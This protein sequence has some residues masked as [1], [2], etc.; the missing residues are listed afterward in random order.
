MSTAFWSLCG[1]MHKTIFW[2][3][4]TLTSWGARTVKI[5]YNVSHSE[6]ELQLSV[7]SV[8]SE[9]FSI[10][11]ITTESSSENF[12]RKIYVLRRCYRCWS[13]T[14]FK[15]KQ[16]HGQSHYFS[17]VYFKKTPGRITGTIPSHIMKSDICKW[18]RQNFMTT[19]WSDSQ[20]CMKFRER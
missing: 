1:L 8:P 13:I 14:C 18:W 5:Q 4:K 9:P 15:R 6:L 7:S 19:S 17:T 20:K 12:G 10:W 3:L 11:E 16:N 2:D